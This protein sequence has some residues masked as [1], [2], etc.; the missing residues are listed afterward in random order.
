MPESLRMARVPPLGEPRGVLH[1]QRFSRIEEVVEVLGLD[2]PPL[3]RFVL[4]LVATEVRLCFGA[5]RAR[6]KRGK[7]DGDDGRQPAKRI[8]GHACPAGVP[9]KKSLAGCGGKARA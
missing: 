1:E 8:T 9:Q 4:D 3:E 2:D 7:S 5:C 6:G